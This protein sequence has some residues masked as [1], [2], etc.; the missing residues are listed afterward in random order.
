MH[1]LCTQEDITQESTIPAIRSVRQGTDP[2]VFLVV[3]S[4]IGADQA[5]KLIIQWSDLRHKLNTGGAF[6]LL[7]GN[8]WIGEI[9][10]FVLVAIVGYWLL[11]HK[12]VLPRERLSLGLLIGGGGSNLLDRL[13]HHGVVDF[14]HLGWGPYFNLAD[15]A[16]AT[17]VLITVLNL[18]Q[19]RLGRCLSPVR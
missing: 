12:Q 9:V 8:E 4:V 5:T 1:P 18:L 13:W 16:I 2:A 15:L 3:V 14:I 19:Q 17:A 7:P 6:G 11:R 10:T